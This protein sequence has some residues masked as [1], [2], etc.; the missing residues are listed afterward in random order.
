MLWHQ[1]PMFPKLPCVAF[2]DARQAT[3][4]TQVCNL[5]GPSGRCLRW[6][7]TAR[8]ATHTW[9]HS[10]VRVPRCVLARKWAPPSS[11][12]TCRVSRW[13]P[14]LRAPSGSGKNRI[15]A[16]PSRAEEQVKVDHWSSFA[17]LIGRLVMNDLFARAR[18]PANG[19]VSTVRDSND[20]EWDAQAMGEAALG[21]R[22][23]I[24]GLCTRKS[25][26]CLLLGATLAPLPESSPLRVRSTTAPRWRRR[27]RRRS[28]AG[29]R[30][31]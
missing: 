28:G 29:P 16:E 8:R 2:R 14:L 24:Y 15:K 30:N 26:T 19:F 12:Y 17:S 13:A 11:R 27:R 20:D 21:E 9:R 6:V 22:S 5:H 18:E 7:W 3:K 25:L 1:N 23:I 31:D 10:N 4:Q